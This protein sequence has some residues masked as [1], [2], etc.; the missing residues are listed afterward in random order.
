MDRRGCK[1]FVLGIDVGGT[2][3]K[4][5]LFEDSGTL[6]ARVSTPTGELVS[7][8]GIERAINACEQL[9]RDNQLGSQDIVGVG[10]D[11]PGPVDERGKVGM[12]AN[13]KLD[14][15]ALTEALSKAFPLAL[16]S[17]INDANAA[18]LGELWQGAARGLSSAVLV[19]LGTGVGGGVVV[20]GHMVAGAFG[21]G[22]EIGHITVNRDETRVCGCGRKGCLEQYASAKGMVHTYR[23]LCKEAEVEPMALQGPTDTYT[24]FKAAREGDAY[25]TGA[26][27]KMADTLA[28]AFAQISCVVDPEVFLIGGGVAAGF[29]LFEE[30]LVKAFVRYCL[31]PCT[32]TRIV[33]A[34]LGNDA[35]IYGCAYQVLCEA[36]KLV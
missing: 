11:V 19:T 15:A 23:E 1:S 20:D 24:I 27:D 25:A 13:I 22:G 5:G 14:M 9:V 10:L 32:H 36:N 30:R 3:V 33:A 16:L 2:S 21:A 12:L 6:L 18:A 17:C 4:C 7:P 29:D 31:P 8:L 35:G 26:I 28:F 34:R